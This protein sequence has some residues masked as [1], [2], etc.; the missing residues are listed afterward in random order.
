MLSSYRVYNKKDHREII[1]RGI[2]PSP[3]EYDAFVNLSNNKGLINQKTD[4]ENTVVLPDRSSY[5]TRIDKL[6]SRKSK[7]VKVTFNTKH[8]VNKEVRH[9]LDMES[10]IQSCLD[11][12]LNNS[13]FRKKGYKLE[14]CMDYVKFVNFILSQEMYY[15][16]D[17]LYLQLIPQKIVLENFLYQFLKNTPLTNILCTFIL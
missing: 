14:S 5:V 7:F 16:L 3:E 4:K 12:L 10:T 11:D 13:Y 6:L 8:K 17:L 15:H 9:L 2:W 1:C